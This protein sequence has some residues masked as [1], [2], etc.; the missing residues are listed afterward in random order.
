MVCGDDAPTSMAVASP[1]AK[2]SVSFAKLHIPH[3]QM[4][5]TIEDFESMQPS[6]AVAGQM[7][8]IDGFLQRD[9]KDG[10]PFPRRRK[11]YLGYTNEN[12][13]VVCLCFDAEPN[14]IRT[15][16]VRRRA[17]QRRRPVRFVLDTF[18]RPQN[19]G[20]LLRESLRSAGKTAFE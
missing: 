18:Q 20:L 8:K 16:M 2:D 6:P 13:Y 7:L 11:V 3:L 10:S 1:H 14:K 19:R 12:L 17:D 15:H 9:P 4:R 5:P